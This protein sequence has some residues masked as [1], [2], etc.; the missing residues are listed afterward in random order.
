[1]L[2]Y[3]EFYK[4]FKRVDGKYIL[5]GRYS[6]NDSKFVFEIVDVTFIA[7]GKR[8]EYSV[9]DKH[10][11]E[12]RNTSFPEGRK[13]FV[14]DQVEKLFTQEELKQFLDESLEKVKPECMEV[15][16]IIK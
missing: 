2:L 14:K 10:S 3:K 7:N 1:M 4:E 12:F 6:V 13:N 11:W 8:K 16:D 9:L 15:S 5:K